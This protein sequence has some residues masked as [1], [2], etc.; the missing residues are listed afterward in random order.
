MGGIAEKDFVGLSVDA[1]GGDQMAR[2]VLTQS[3]HHELNFGH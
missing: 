1:A 2:E 3:G